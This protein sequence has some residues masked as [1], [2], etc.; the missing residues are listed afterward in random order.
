MGIQSYL[1]RVSKATSDIKEAINDMGGTCDACASITTLASAVRA[2]PTT[3]SDG[4]SLFTVLAFKQSTT[5]PSTPS[6][7]SWSNSSDS[8][9]YPSGWSDGAGLTKNVWLSYKI[10]KA[11]GSIYKNWVEPIIINGLLDGDDPIDLTDLATKTWVMSQLNASGVV[12]LNGL[13]GA[14]NLVAGSDNVTINSSGKNISI[15]VSGGSGGEGDDGDTYMPVAIYILTDSKT[16]KPATPSGG[17]YNFTSNSLE[18]VPSGWSI[19]S[20]SEVGKYTWRSSGIFS[21]KN[22]G[23]QVGTWGTP[24]CMTG[25]PGPKGEDGDEIEIVYAVSNNATIP[26]LN[27]SGTDSNGLTKASDGYLPKFVFTDSTIEAVSE[28]PSVSSTNRYRYAAKRRKHNGTWLSFS[29]PYVDGNFVS[30]GLT[31]EEKEQIKTDVS[32]DLTSELAKAEENVIKLETRLDKIDGTD[33]TFMVDKKEAIIQAITQ[34]K[35]ENQTSFSDLVLDGSEAKLS[36]IVGSEIENGVKT[37]LAGA[38]V[39]LDGLAGKLNSFTTYQEKTDEAVKKLNNVETR[40]NAAEGKLDNVADKTYVDE[41]TNTKVTNMAKQTLDAAKAEIRST[42]ATGTWIWAIWENDKDAEN[43]EDLNYT[44]TGKILETKAYDTRMFLDWTDSEGKIHT[45]V[46][47][48]DLPD[49]DP[50]NDDVET[51]VIA[52]FAPEYETVTNSDGT[53]EKKVKTTAEEKYRAYVS[54]TTSAT[55]TTKKWV[56]TVQANAF[57]KI[58]QDAGSIDLTAYGEEGSL[59]RIFLNAKKKG[60]SITFEADTFDFTEGSII[61]ADN[62]VLKNLSVT[63]NANHTTD[64]SSYG[65]NINYAYIN[66]C[67]INNC[68]IESQLKS[69]KYS[70]GESSD[71]NGFLF[72]AL[73]DTGEFAIYGKTSAGEAFE[74]TNDSFILPKA[75]IGQLS[76]GELTGGDKVVTGEQIV[77]TVL[78]YLNGSIWPDIKKLIN[79]STDLVVG[80]VQAT[81]GDASNVRQVYVGN[82]TDLNIIRNSVSLEYPD[83]HIISA[84]DLAGKN[85]IYVTYYTNTIEDSSTEASLWFAYSSVMS[86]V[87][88][89]SPKTSCGTNITISAYLYKS[90]GTETTST[91]SQTST[92][93]TISFVETLIDNQT[94][95]Q[96]Q[97]VGGVDN[98]PSSLWT[99]CTY[100]TTNAAGPHKGGFDFTGLNGSYGIVYLFTITPSGTAIEKEV[101][102]NVYPPILNVNRD[103]TE[104]RRGVF[105]SP[106]GILVNASDSETASIRINSDN[107]IESEGFVTSIGANSVDSIKVVG[108][109]SECTSANTL[110]IILRS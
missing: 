103:S 86:Y 5:K 68:T 110:Y 45:H 106:D 83:A 89:Y 21:K 74:I 8:I 52:G 80:T 31:D 97:F 26:S 32:Q 96:K 64:N 58:I 19:D 9:T 37:T 49:A 22:N 77:D 46:E 43:A 91:W 23:A 53:S 100:I 65:A 109:T 12:S 108:T 7:G 35:K 28:V 25:D 72:D 11:D 2:I 88:N 4:T 82:E 62:L 67:K 70:N 75:V 10:Y 98:L 40:L 63:G 47:G 36:G 85:P 24:I 104:K 44:P 99:N 69:K 41:T 17:T 79:A 73:S 92:K 102:L 51:G 84:T 3:G 107:E 1:K 94:M 54:N 34:Y 105:I 30:A 101:K 61:N 16:N 48:K 56:R 95:V 66:D 60:S 76:I 33:A 71:K 50:N 27:E 42:A 38:G 39:E 14:I 55:Y 93:P 15:A 57:S 6:G 90:D 59:A 13:T 20:L 78:A 18:N 29:S 87:T 81:G